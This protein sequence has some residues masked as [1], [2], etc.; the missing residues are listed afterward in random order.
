MMESDFLPATHTSYIRVIK[1]M[2]RLV[3]CNWALSNMKTQKWKV[4]IVD[5]LQANAYVL[6]V[7]KSWKFIFT[8]LKFRYHLRFFYVYFHYLL[9][10]KLWSLEDEARLDN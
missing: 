6:A 7:S 3:H 4:A 10:M 5:S 9:L 8:S 2:E 1:I